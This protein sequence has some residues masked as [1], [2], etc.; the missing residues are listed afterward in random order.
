MRNAHDV[1]AHGQGEINCRAEPQDRREQITALRLKRARV[2]HR[3]ER[4]GLRTSQ[5]DSQVVRVPLQVPLGGVSG[6]VERHAASDDRAFGVCERS[7][8]SYRWCAAAGPDARRARLG[9]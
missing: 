9:C 7:S 4:C 3:G 5:H 6:G 8:A 2:V 1:L